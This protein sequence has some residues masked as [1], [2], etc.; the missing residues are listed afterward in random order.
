MK[1]SH[2]GFTLAEVLITLVII[3]VIAAI[4]V[5]T[6]INNANNKSNV[7]MW[8]KTFSDINNAYTS[9]IADNGFKFS[10]ICSS[11]DN[12][13]CLLNIFAKKLSVIK[14][15]SGNGIETECWKNK[16]FG[17]LGNYSAVIL[18]NGVAIALNHEY[19]D[20]IKYRPGSNRNCGHILV[21]VN[22]NK[23][24]NMPGKDIFGMY[25]W[26][27]KIEPW[28]KNSAKLWD[29][30]NTNICNGGSEDWGCGAQYLYNSPQ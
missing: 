15:C 23:K 13:N 21:D 2:N 28:G 16:S 6:I 18:N 22:G 12:N 30:Y 26:Q 29:Q 3:G 19:N 25:I 14:T 11:T 9:A 5:P 1:N 27:N 20:C 4:T 10:N 8:K 24:P 7:T 17:Y